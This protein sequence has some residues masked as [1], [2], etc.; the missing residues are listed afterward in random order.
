MVC[1]MEMDVT[2]KFFNSPIFKRAL[3]EAGQSD[4]TKHPIGCVIFKGKNI[5]VSSHNSVR[6]SNKVP[7]RFKEFEESLHAECAAI[8]KAKKDLSGYSLLVVRHQKSG[9]IMTA[10]PCE[11]CLGFIKYVGIKRIFYSNSLG[12]IVE[13]C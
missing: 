10:K 3:E 2:Y 5:L 4:Y 12:Q 11:L 13:E 1:K 8:I 6:A 7:K 9:R